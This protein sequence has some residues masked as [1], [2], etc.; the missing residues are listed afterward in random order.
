MKLITQLTGWTLALVIITGCQRQPIV[1]GTFTLAKDSC[2]KN[3][4]VVNPDIK[5]GALISE[6]NAQQYPFIPESREDMNPN[7]PIADSVAR[8][9]HNGELR[10][11]GWPSL[12]H[13]S[14]KKNGILTK[15]WSK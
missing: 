13:P 1:E 6:P 10:I 5:F 2:F 8:L 11:T 9:S 3:T 4:L 14:L 12:G 15:T 7:L